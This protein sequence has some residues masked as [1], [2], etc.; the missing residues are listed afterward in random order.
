MVLKN[1]KK[2]FFLIFF[3]WV[4]YVFLHVKLPSKKEPILL[5]SNQC[6]DDLKKVLLT[7]LKK[8]KQSI[9]LSMFTIKDPDILKILK[10]KKL[11]KQIFFDKK[12]SKNSPL[13]QASAIKTNSLMHQKILVIDKKIS[14]IGSCNMTLPSLLMDNNLLIGIRDKKIA[15][16]LFQNAPIKSGFI[17]TNI[18]NQ[19][20]TIFLLPNKKA[21]LKIKKIIKNAKKSIK[22]GMFTLSQ[23]ELLEEIIKAKTRKVKI[24]VIVDHHTK[25]GAS[26]IAFEKLNKNIFFSQGQELFHHKYLIVDNN[27]L[28]S[29]SLNWTNAGFTKNKEIIFILKNLKKPQKKF[30]KKL[31]KIAEIEANS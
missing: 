5:Y 6:G 11:E 7:S 10:N 14:F 25:F 31:H 26:K 28:V 1:K 20:I 23:K 24:S 22:I 9:F 30:L 3:L 8:A 15:N 17:K 12:F 27:I 13:K 2:I 29:G 18:S 21:F 19:K 16:F 4:L